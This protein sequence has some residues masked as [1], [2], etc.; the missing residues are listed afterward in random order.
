MLKQREHIVASKPGPRWQF[1]IDV[2]GTFTDCFGI[3][4]LGE[5]I[6]RKILSSGRLRC[7]A[8][9]R[10]STAAAAGGHFNIQLPFAVEARSV[11]GLWCETFDVAGNVIARGRVAEFD[12]HSQVLKSQEMVP[13]TQRL[14]TDGSTPPVASIELFSEQP[15]PL[16]AIRL[17]IGLGVTETIPSVDLRLGTT[18]GTNA[19]LTRSGAPTALV[20]T[21]GFG[22]ALAIGDQQ[23]TDLFALQ[24]CKVPPLYRIAVEV[25]ER[26][27]ADGSIH[28]PLDELRAQQVLMDLKRQGIQSLAVCLLHSYKQP[29]HEERIAE[30]AQPL[31][32]LN[33]SLSHRCSPLIKFI[34]RASTT[35]LDAYL[36]P[37]LRDY[38]ALIERELGEESR[39]LLMTSSGGLVAPEKFSGKDSVLSGPAGGVVGFSA[40]AR[41]AGCT[42]AIG[43]DMGG[44]ST[45]V[46]RFDGT[47]AMQQETRKA[48]VAIQ[49]PTLAIETVAA[50]GGSVCWYDG[51]R[52]LVGPHSAGADPGPAC[53]GRGGPL[54]ISDVNYWMG[55]IPSEGFP[56]PLQRNAV[57]RALEA[58]ARRIQQESSIS[59]TTDELAHAFLT[60]ANSHIAG[61]LAAVSTQQGVDPRDYPIV[62]FGGAAAQHACGVADLLGIQ[63]IIVHPDAGLLSAYGI[64]HSPVSRIAQRHVDQVLSSVVLDEILR[65]VPE[66]TAEASEQLPREHREKNCVIDSTMQLWLSV[67]GTDQ[68]MPIALDPL[69]YL[70]EPEIRFE[71]WQ[72]FES[73][74]GHRWDRPLRVKA[75][76]VEVS[77]VA[78]SIRAALA[79]S[80]SPMMEPL[81]PTDEPGTLLG[82][83][84]RVIPGN[85]SVL[86]LEDGWT[87]KRDAAGIMVLTRHSAVKDA[88]ASLGLDRAIGK[89]SGASHSPRDPLMLELFSQRLTEIATQMGLTL[90]ATCTSVNVKE[91]LDFSCAAFDSLGHLLVNAPHIPV[92]LGA[93]SET[94]QAIIRHFPNV[95][96]DDVFVTN[97]PFQG[98]SHLPDITV[99]SPVFAFEDSRDSR[100]QGALL[101]WVASRAHHAEIG[102]TTP[103]SLP[104]FAKCLEE[105]GVVLRNLKWMDNGRP[106]LE[107]VRGV[108]L[109]GKYPSRSPETNLV[110]IQAQVA[111]N[112]IGQ[113]RLRQFA[114]EWGHDGIVAYCR[115]I[116]DS[117]AEHTGLLLRRFKPGIYEFS[118]QLDCGLTIRLK[119]TIEPTQMTV[120]FA[121]TDPRSENNLNTNPAIVQAA[122]MYCLRT[123]IAVPIPLNQGVMRPIQLRLPTCFL[124]PIAGSEGNATTQVPAAELPAVGGGN[125]ETS[126][127]LVDVIFGAL[128][129][130]GASQGTMNNF[131]FGNDRFGFYETMGGGCGATSAGPGADAIHSHMTNTRLTDPEILE[132]R[133]PVKLLAFQIRSGSGGKGRNPG[134]NGMVRRFLFTEAL[135][136]SL[137]T[138][139]RNPLVAAPYGMGGGQ[140]GQRGRNILIKANAKP[141][142]LP[143][144]CYFP[145]TPGDVVEIHTPGGGGW[146]EA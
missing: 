51:Q 31:G 50:G 70:T 71:F 45:D 68:T 66:L 76:E 17:I 128:Q 39:L 1:W 42:R 5:T 130:A 55:R 100:R 8:T 112:R 132:S 138:N 30:L 86:W 93:M 99:V 29:I 65:Q 57:A 41:Q 106:Q 137:V 118:D 20:T 136:V 120:D 25:C 3:S 78:N 61:A 115:H 89:L 12:A 119:I 75:L 60:V 28:T 90:Q 38:V 108:L 81:K 124:N 73:R 35:V 54:T 88:P 127:R 83:G 32:F 104:P 134:G 74:F 91:R 101:F 19:L 107:L 47:V 16:V 62:A 69:R 87:A 46:A 7:S 126:Q 52:L 36:N 111:A 133:Y 49:T 121:G 59:Y 140:P 116:Q 110:D 33:V 102:G 40:V 58:L 123:L 98:G 125:V 145:V 142:E 18:R 63:K 77:S 14:A 94:V 117:A 139:R 103:G 131:L 56:M 109:S 27:S 67:E 44:T 48:G 21:Q 26:V 37:V 13:A 64:G 129:V 95:H 79:S 72:Q 43:L 146:G 11:Q 23:R 113:Q 10:P 15:A 85:Y 22:D 122:V 105:E 144:S 34:S 24:V 2:G 82:E 80:A 84:P 4:P 141:Q 135:Q 114:S 143:G 96:P 97:D 9:Q 53:Y 6:R 92:H